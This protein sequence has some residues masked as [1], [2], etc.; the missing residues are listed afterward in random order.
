MRK[1]QRQA[2]EKLRELFCSIG[3]DDWPEAH[4]KARDLLEQMEDG[5]YPQISRENAKLLLKGYCRH[6]IDI[7]R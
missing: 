1:Q 6:V 3:A 7:A 5:V 2:N 4:D